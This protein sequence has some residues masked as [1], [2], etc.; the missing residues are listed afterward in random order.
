MDFWRGRCLKRR[1]P[2][3]CTFGLSGCRVKPRR[4]WGRRGFTRPRERHKKSKT[5]AG[6]G[7]KTRNFG[8]PPFGAPPWGA[9][10]SGSTLRVFVLPCF[11]HLVVFFSKK[12]KGQ[13]TETPNFGQ[14]RFGQSR[15]IKVGQSRSNK[16]GQSRIGQSR[17]QPTFV[18][19]TSNLEFSCVC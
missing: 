8:P 17:H 4:L 1:G 18:V 19:F 13:K 10:P 16:D 15:P 5:V 6:K 14:S 11:G 2:E 9:H 12:T 3:M 7:K